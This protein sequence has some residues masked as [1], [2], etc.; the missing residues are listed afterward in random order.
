MGSENIQIKKT[1]MVNKLV[2]ESFGRGW[3][4]NCLPSCSESGGVVGTIV[5]TGLGVPMY[6]AKNISFIFS[7]F[8]IAGE[9]TEYDGSELTVFPEYLPQAQS[10]SKLYESLTGK[11]VGIQTKDKLR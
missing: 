5:H 8:L 4:G 6:I 1:E 9:F 2:E 11:T 10:Y 3:K 7:R